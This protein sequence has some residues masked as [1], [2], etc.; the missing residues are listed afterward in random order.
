MKL[1]RRGSHHS[2]GVTK[3]TADMSGWIEKQGSVSIIT[4]W[5]KRFLTLSKNVLEYFQDDSLTLKKGDFSLDA[6]TTVYESQ[7]DDCLFTIKSSSSSFT[8]KTD[9]SNSRHNWVVA[10]NFAVSS[11]QV[12]TF[13]FIE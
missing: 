9:D 13:V 7:D 3:S 5:K 8:I 2:T 1:F 12:V 4:S 11:L 10:I 6:R